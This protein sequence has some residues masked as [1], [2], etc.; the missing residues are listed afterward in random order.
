MKLLALILALAV[1]VT[2]GSTDLPSLSTV[3]KTIAVYYGDPGTGKAAKHSPY[4]TE[5]K[6]LLVAPPAYTE[7]AA[8]VVDVDDTTLLTYNME[9]GA[10]EFEFD[11]ATKD[12]WVKYAKFPATP[13]MVEYLNSAASAGFTIFAVTGRAKKYAADTKRNLAKVGYP[14]MALYTKACTCSTVAYKS[15]VRQKIQARGYDI[16]LN[17]GDQYSDLA[18]GYADTTIKLPN[19]MYYIGPVNKKTRTSFNLKSDGSSGLTAGGEG[20][21]N[22]DLVEKYRK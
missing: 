3:K 13:G 1:T 17:I 11:R 5:M 19:P 7:N 8:I 12:R 4:V 9:V 22:F 16:V 14:A 2:P 6:K 15:G 21:P 10:Y 20:I 18:G